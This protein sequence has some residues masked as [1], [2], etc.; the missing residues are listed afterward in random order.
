VI[1]KKGDFK[2]YVAQNYSW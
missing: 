1:H 2:K